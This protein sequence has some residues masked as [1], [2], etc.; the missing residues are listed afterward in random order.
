M[1]GR[2]SREDWIAAGLHALL[3]EGPDAVAVQP[4]AR[5][6]GATKGSFY[7]HFDSRDDL[8]R[9][10]L[11]RWETVATHD[12]IAELEASEAAP[13]EKVRR[14]FAAVTA[15]S[16]RHPGQLLLLGGVHHPDV[17][18]AVERTTE[19]R[20]GYVAR[21]LGETGVPPTVAVRRA[22]LAYAAYLGHA[23]LLRTTPGVLPSKAEERGKLIEE[24]TAIVLVKDAHRKN[25]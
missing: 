19:R 11:A 10:V 18:A 16:A 8:L 12:V 3:N 20:I 9:A 13:E 23:Q 14:L 1:S 17:A 24:M 7:W 4:I 22:T 21:L 6:L 25:R 15:G 2:R 5:S